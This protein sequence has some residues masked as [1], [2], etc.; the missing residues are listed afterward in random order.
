LI[1]CSL[2][3]YIMDFKETLQRYHISPL[4]YDDGVELQEKDY[5]ELATVL[6][7]YYYS[8]QL[9]GNTCKIPKIPEPLAKRANQHI[10][11]SLLDVDLE[12]IMDVLMEQTGGK[13]I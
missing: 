5:Y 7:K 13:V 12:S 3:L 8:K 1:I 10:K 4:Q 9:M 2:E 11:R 6:L